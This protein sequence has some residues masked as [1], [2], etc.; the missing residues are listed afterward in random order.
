[1][2]EGVAGRKRKRRDGEIKSHHGPEPYGQEKQQVTE[3]FIA[4]E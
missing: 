4:G 1:M 2:R 3:D